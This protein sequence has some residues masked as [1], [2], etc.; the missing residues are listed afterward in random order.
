K[1]VVPIPGYTAKDDAVDPMKLA[2]FRALEEQ[3]ARVEELYRSG[4]GS[5]KGIRGLSDYLPTDANAAFDSASAGLGEVGLAAF[6]VP[7]VGSQSDT[8]LRQF[9]AANTPRASDRDAAI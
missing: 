6:R 4:P 1:G 2:Q 3:I 8:E 7:G 9:V 5:T